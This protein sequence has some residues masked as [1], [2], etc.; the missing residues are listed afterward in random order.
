MAMKIGMTACLFSYLFIT[1]LFFT[2]FGA[3]HRNESNG[4]TG[5]GV[6]VRFGR[7]QKD[8]PDLPHGII[9]ILP[10]V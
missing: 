7:S 9:T 1:R 6:I 2:R 5:T 8:F 3:E 10:V 4:G